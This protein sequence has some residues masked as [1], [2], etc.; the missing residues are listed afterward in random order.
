VLI[1]DDKLDWNMPIEIRGSASAKFSVYRTSV[2]ENFLRLED[3][4]VKEGKIHYLAP[5]KSV[6]GF[7]TI[8]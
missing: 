4:T 3:V 8:I 6:S 1:N 5:A 7:Y 2:S